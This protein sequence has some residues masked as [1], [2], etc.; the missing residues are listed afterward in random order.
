MSE[1]ADAIPIVQL[2]I[3]GLLLVV[4]GWV[5]W[6]ILKGHLVPRVTLTDAREDRDHWRTVAEKERDGHLE[7]R[8]QVSRLIHSAKV[9]DHSW[10]SMRERGESA[11]GTT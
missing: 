3:D 8:S 2:G 1:L 10:E 7:T 11:G 6:A 5:V 4:V 9:F